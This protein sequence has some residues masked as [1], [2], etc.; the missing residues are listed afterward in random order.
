MTPRST[1]QLPTSGLFPLPTWAEEGRAELHCYRVPQEWTSAGSNQGKFP[2]NRNEGGEDLE[3][4]QN[5]DHCAKGPR[6]NSQ[7]PHTWKTVAQHW[8][9]AS[10]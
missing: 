10:P 6:F 1:T 8:V 2:K 3:L 4:S 5:I 9:C 7:L